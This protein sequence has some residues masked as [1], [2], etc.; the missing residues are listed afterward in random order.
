M[1]FSLVPD[2]S[3]DLVT[4]I[5]AKLL[6]GGGVSLLLVDLDNTLA[7]YSDEGPSMEVLGWKQSLEREGIELFIVSNTKT[8]RAGRYAAALGINYVNRARKPSTKAVKA[9]IE[10]LGHTAASSALVGDQIFTDVLCANRCGAVSI[11]VKPIK[12]G[13][14]F[15][16]VRYFFEIP[17]RLM[18]KNKL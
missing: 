18:C 8:D 9:V 15:F 11:V 4:R 5:D 17:F 16:A 10:S 7:S 14:P 2:I 13:N 1:K 3:A 12:F 6:K